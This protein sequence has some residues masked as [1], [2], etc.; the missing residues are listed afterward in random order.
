MCRL[1]DDQIEKLDKLVEELRDT[2]EVTDNYYTD[3]E[4]NAYAEFV[5]SVGYGGESIHAVEDRVR[6]L[7]KDDL[8]SDT[9]YDFF[10]AVFKFK[11][12]DAAQIIADLSD[13]RFINNYR[14]VD[15]EVYSINLGEIEDQ[16]PEDL[17]DKIK[18]LNDDERSYLIDQSRDFCGLMISSDN[19]SAYYYTDH[20]YERWALI[21]DT[22]RL[23]EKIT[24]MMMIGLSVS[25]NN[26]EPKKLEVI[27]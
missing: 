27:R 23:K 21:L 4:D 26:K 19:K 2:V 18:A 15:Y 1:N 17:F 22:D 8:I 14:A 25:F 3:N 16:V 20:N 5:S 10:K 9:D 7:W 11:Q 6:S 13:L 12:R 24:E